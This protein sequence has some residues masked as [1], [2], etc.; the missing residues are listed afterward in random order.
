MQPQESTAG[1]E[2]DGLPDSFVALQQSCEE[3]SATAAGLPELRLIVQQ[4]EQ[5]ATEV[6]QLQQ[7]KEELA[8]VPQQLLQLRQE[9]D[10][11]QQM[12]EEQQVMQV[13]L[14]RIG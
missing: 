3:L 2:A 1:S 7:R 11:L 10:E 13:R 8:G 5:D 6:V 12:A 14:C 9:V 4:L